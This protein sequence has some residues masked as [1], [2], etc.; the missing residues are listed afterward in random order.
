MDKTVILLGVNGD[1]GNALLTKFLSHDQSVIG[2]DLHH[3]ARH[4]QLDSYFPC[5]VTRIDMVH[6]IIEQLKKYLSKD[7]IVISCIG[8]FGPPTYQ[9]HNFNEAQFLESVNTNLIGVSIFVNQL[10]TEFLKL[11]NHKMRIVLVGSTASQV[12][13]LDIGYS[14]SKAG[15]NGLVRSISKSLSADGVTCMGVNPGIFES[16]M[17]RSVSEERQQ[18]AMNDTHLKRVGTLSE[19]ADVIYYVG[20]NAPDYLTGSIIPLN[21]GQI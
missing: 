19:V 3:K 12:G 17:S 6:D 10:I 15:L 1:L 4:N 18:K 16:R 13:S 2:V 20:N 9:E 8:K 14:V 11:N 5:D 21:G 7:L